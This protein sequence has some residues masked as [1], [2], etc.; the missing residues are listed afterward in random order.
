MF[1]ENRIDC[2]ERTIEDQRKLIFVVILD[3][4]II[5]PPYL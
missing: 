3:I 1:I 2:A 4:E 5:S